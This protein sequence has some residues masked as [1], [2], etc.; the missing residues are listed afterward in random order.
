MF[1]ISNISSQ[2]GQIFLNDYV[3][4]L[5]HYCEKE[6]TKSFI[7]R[8]EFYNDNKLST[9]FF[10]NHIVCRRPAGKAMT[11][12][13]R[14]TFFKITLS[15]G[16]RKRFVFKTFIDNDKTRELIEEFYT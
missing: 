11:I 7:L 6:L 4:D 12:N 13:Y 8:K 15:A 3:R 10:Q 5:F 14:P 2:E 1:C 16:G 9:N